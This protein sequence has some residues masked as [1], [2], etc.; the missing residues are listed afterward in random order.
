M[1]RRIVPEGTLM[2][3][4]AARWLRALWAVLAL[5][6]FCVGCHRAPVSPPEEQYTA[7]QGKLAEIGPTTIELRTKSGLWTGLLSKDCH[8]EVT[9]RV[10][11]NDIPPGSPISV[12]ING[13]GLAMVVTRL[14]PG[15]RTATFDGLDAVKF[16]SLVKL[17]DK[18]VTFQST[19]GSTS[20]LHL[21]PE[22]R[23]SVRKRI[24]PEEMKHMTRVVVTFGKGDPPTVINVLDI[25]V[26]KRQ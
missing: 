12:R 2:P 3:V 15:F 18:T 14:H 22:A 5:S 19:N 26:L 20:T 6:L 13:A 4:R 16:G 8:F 17:S 1:T 23:F 10:A 11:P 7:L 21:T 25:G 9:R 24:K